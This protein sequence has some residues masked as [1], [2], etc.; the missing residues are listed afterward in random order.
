MDDVDALVK[1]GYG[2][3]NRVRR[4]CDD[5]VDALGLPRGTAKE[6]KALLAAMQG[7]EWP[8]GARQA[9]E[10]LDLV[11][12]LFPTRATWCAHIATQVC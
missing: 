6:L 2:S 4:M 9:D 5:D 1:H 10:P 7:Q 11:F 3:L 8:A 12:S